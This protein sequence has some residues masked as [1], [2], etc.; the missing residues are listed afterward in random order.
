MQKNI[1][2]EKHRLQNQ[3][4]SIVPI[5]FKKILCIHQNVDS[6]ISNALVRNGDSFKIFYFNYFYTYSNSL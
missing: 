2:K 1:I 6:R 5:L 3:H 4:Y